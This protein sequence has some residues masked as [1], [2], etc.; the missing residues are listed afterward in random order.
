VTGVVLLPA[1]VKVVAA[2]LIALVAGALVAAM[3][4]AFLRTAERGEAWSRGDMSSRK[5]AI[6]ELVGLGSID[7]DEYSD[8]QAALLRE[9]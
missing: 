7:P 9:N 3:V 6:D 2:A 4:A 1:A 5:R 8:R